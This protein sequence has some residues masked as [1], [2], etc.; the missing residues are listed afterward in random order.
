M[1]KKLLAVSFVLLVAPAV[2]FPRP[3]HALFI[4]DDLVALSTKEYV[5]DPIFHALGRVAIDSISKSMT[6]WINSGF[7]G[8]PAFVTDLNLH[9]R[10]LGDA[11]A[12]EFLT[13][14]MNSSA[15]QSPFISQVLQG[16]GA[17]YYL[18]TSKDAFAEKLRY[19]LNQVARNDSAFLAGDFSQGG[20]N[21]WFSATLNRANNPVGAQ[22]LAGEE[23]AKRIQSATLN[24]AKELDHG[25]GFLAWRGDCMVPGKIDAT[26]ADLGASNEDNCLKHEIRTPGSLIVDMTPEPMRETLRSLGVADEL[27][28]VLSALMSQLISQGLQDFRGLSE[29]T[30]GGGA[31]LIDRA[32]DPSNYLNTGGG[33]MGG[34]LEIVRAQRT[35]LVKFQTNWQTIQTAANTA[36]QEC[37]SDTSK[38][39]KADE[40]LSRANSTLNTISTILT[41]LTAI[42]ASA[43]AAASATTDQTQQVL[44]LT[45]RY[46]AFQGQLPTPDEVLYAADQSRDTGDISP[47]SLYTQMK[48]L[49]ASCQ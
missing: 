29:P 38:A 1:K 21:A 2:F 14:V 49:A 47:S 28:E 9:F 25:R 18:D 4:V 19:T 11:K 3:A 17:A 30:A 7:N 5:L 35:E 32:T 26:A 23:L 43:T 34:F 8:S 13:D 22:L 45:A 20:W 44:A 41:E 36:R 39:A 10:A 48:D 6:N 37:S 15:V 24:R 42:E 12:K 33:V 16:V 31:S 40:V 27:N 46:Q